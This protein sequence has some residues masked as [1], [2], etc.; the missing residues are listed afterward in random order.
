MDKKSLCA[1]SIEDQK[2]IQLAI[3]EITDHFCREN[4]IQY[5]LDS[6]TLLG[7]VRH[8]GYIPWDDDIDIGML[9]SDFERFI[10]T[11]NESNSRYQVICNELDRHCFYPYAKVVDTETVL[12]EP[13]ENG[14]QLCINIDIFVYDVTPDEEK[15][16]RQ[17]VLRDR[18]AFLNAAQFGLLRPKIWYKKMLLVFMRQMLHIFPKGFFAG[19]MVQNS[20]KY[21]G[22]NA[23]YVG[24]FTAFSKI[25]CSIHVFDSFLSGNFEGKS[26][27]IPVGYDQWLR[28]FYGD[29]MVLPPVEERVTHHTK[30]AFFSR[31]ESAESL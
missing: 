22:S 29:Y 18:L 14:L 6:G 9:R 19:K 8:Q 30:I 27:P 11:F 20:R 4:G 28:T 16:R 15:S 13:D 1:A 3:L 5:W 31:A 24:N 12:Y 26:Y 25:L 21:D 23:E 10:T 7:A 17:Y 2:R